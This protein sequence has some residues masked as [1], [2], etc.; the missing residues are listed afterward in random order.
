M[1]YRQHLLLQTPLVSL[2]IC[3][4]SYFQHPSFENLVPSMDLEA[5]DPSIC[6]F[7]EAGHSEATAGNH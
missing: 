4:G 2:P 7:L 6:G 1:S 3:E 5:Q